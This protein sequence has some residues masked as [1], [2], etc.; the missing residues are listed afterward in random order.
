MRGWDRGG[1]NDRRGMLASPFPHSM[2]FVR[3]ENGV[4][5]YVHSSFWCKLLRGGATCHRGSSLPLFFLST[6]PLP[7]SFLFFRHIGAIYGLVQEGGE[8][9]ERGEEGGGSDKSLV[10]KRGDHGGREG[11]ER[12]G[13][14]GVQSFA[15][16]GFHPWNRIV[17][18]HGGGNSGDMDGILVN[19]D[20]RGPVFFNMGMLVGN[21]EN[22]LEEILMNK[23]ENRGKLIDRK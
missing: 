14:E 15:R 6:P 9:E 4:N 19:L 2:R 22:F 23:W 13:G 8:I 21:V 5:R 17:F 18:F 16:R 10:V 12:R 11:R 3:E 1:A 7:F 20:K